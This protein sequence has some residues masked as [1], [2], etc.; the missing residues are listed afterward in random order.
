MTIRAIVKITNRITDVY[1]RLQVVLASVFMVFMILTV[2]HGV[3]MRYVM[4]SP[5]A[6]SFEFAKFCLMPVTVFALAYT[7][8]RKGHVRVDALVRNLPA[9]A[10]GVLDF[11][12]WLVFLI[13]T[14][15]LCYVGLVMTSVYFADHI[16][17]EEAQFPLWVIAALMVIGLSGLGFQLIVDVV[18]SFPLKNRFSDSNM[19]RN[20][21]ENLR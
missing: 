5:Q 2:V 1:I 4:R 7:Q 16:T 6:Y 21:R 20:I 10:R 13:Y 8:R 12:S 3:F 11:F 14:I 18:K 9:N 19:K 17:S 15:G